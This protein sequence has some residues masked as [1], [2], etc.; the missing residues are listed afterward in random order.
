LYFYLTAK[1]M[2][3]GYGYLPMIRISIVVPVYNEEEYLPALLDSVEE[4][5]ERFIFDPSLIEVIIADNGSTDNTLMI[6]AQRGCRTVHEDRRIIAAVRNTGARVAQGEILA[7][8][9]ADNIIHQDTFNEIE[10]ALASSRI[11]GGATGVRL[12]RMSVGIACAYAII[13]PMVWATG[14]D[15]G[16]IFCRKRDFWDV[17]GYNEGYLFAEDVQFLWGL[18]NH[19]RIRGQRL[20]RIRKCKAMTS[21]RKFDQFGDW[22]YVRLIFKFLLSLIIR[23]YTLE[24]FARKYWYSDER[25]PSKKTIIPN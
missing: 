18:R 20:V 15:T 21:T 22:H 23:K 1:K 10:K 7:F 4:A 13:V 16:V 19:G 9:D 17:G 5:R 3:V 6:A 25:Q 12:E 14:M 2:P 24:G 8:T 11:V